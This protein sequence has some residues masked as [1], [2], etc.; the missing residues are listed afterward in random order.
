[1]TLTKRM[2]LCSI[3]ASAASIASAALYAGTPSVDQIQHSTAVHF[4]SSSFDRPSTVAAL[5][6][7]IAY[8]ADQVC[9]PRTLTGSYATTPGYRRCYADAVA[10]A[11]ARVDQPQLT[12]Y[13]QEQLTP[14]GLALDLK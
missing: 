3:A 8:A 13:Y 5:Y 1:M 10:R 6:H 2:L 14:M 7:R 4:S 11:I 12:A 9:G